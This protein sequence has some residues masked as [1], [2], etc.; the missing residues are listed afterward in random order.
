MRRLCFIEWLLQPDGSDRSTLAD[1][2]PIPSD[3]PRGDCSGHDLPKRLA[4]LLPED[5]SFGAGRHKEERRVGQLDSM[6]GATDQLVES[7]TQCAVDYHAPAKLLDDW[8]SQLAQLGS[9]A[10]DR[11]SV[12]SVYDDLVRWLDTVD[13]RS[14]GWLR[15]VVLLTAAAIQQA[16]GYPFPVARIP[17]HLAP[18]GGD[19]LV[20]I[21]ADA[22][23]SL[24]AGEAESRRAG[25][26]A[27]YWLAQAA[28]RMPEL[29]RLASG[30]LAAYF[31]CAEGRSA[32]TRERSARASSQGVGSR[33]VLDYLR[34]AQDDT[35][36]RGKAKPVWEASSQRVP[37][38]DNWQRRA[39]ERRGLP[40]LLK[41]SLIGPP[42][43]GKSSLLRACCQAFSGRSALPVRGSLTYGEAAEQDGIW[44]A[45]GHV[46]LRSSD[47]PFVV[48]EIPDRL[49]ETRYNSVADANLL[50]VM[51]DATTLA[52]RMDSNLQLLAAI[53]TRYLT[54]VSQGLVAIAYSRADE[55]GVVAPQAIRLVEE[56]QRALIARLDEPKAWED[57]V[58]GKSP[59]SR[60]VNAKGGVFTQLG[61]MARNS[62][63]GPS[64]T[65]LFQQSKWLWG[66]L[67]KSGRAASLLNAY[68][69]FSQ[70]HDPRLKGLS[71]YGYL[72][73][74]AD[75]FQRV[76]KESE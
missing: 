18:R 5:I 28:A 60:S 76:A 30:D 66:A 52:S 67:G 17:G 63:W 31:G 49:L 4:G 34:T 35:V 54:T 11:A 73:I 68:F 40:T 53:V 64:R 2:D 29:R 14:N 58:A 65:W 38:A 23:K 3:W 32:A 57:F 22:L 25:P 51:L 71:E 75:L 8:H 1:L 62:E 20:S 46:T 39:P 69:V 61:V 19:S 37:P 33:R 48:E 47:L 41:V 50:V 12:A 26:L 10:E 45:K 36:L 13:A 59:A 16:S 43:S 21:A 7:L 56:Q 27:F 55:Y 9:K 44:R 42:G 72:P 24:Y 70:T 74:F 6:R 15:A